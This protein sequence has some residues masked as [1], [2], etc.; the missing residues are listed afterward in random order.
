MGISDHNLSG[1]QKRN[2]AHFASVVRLANADGFLSEGEEVLLKRLAKRFHIL[3]EKYKEILNNPEDYPIYTPHSYEERIEHLYDLAKMVFADNEATGDEAKVLKKICV[4]LGF[5][6]DN[7]DKVADE[8]IHLV[9]NDNDLDEFTNAIK[10][11]NK[12]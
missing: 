3:E 9:L 11:V 4:G 2:I 6:I 1:K 12:I 5:P 8:A 7:V 10:K